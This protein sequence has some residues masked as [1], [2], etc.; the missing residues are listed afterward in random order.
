MGKETSFVFPDPGSSYPGYDAAAPTEQNEY[1]AWSLRKNLYDMAQQSFEWQQEDWDA[2]KSAINSKIATLITD[3]KAWI[4]ACYAAV[5]AGNPIPDVPN[6]W[7][8]P[9]STNMSPLTFML[10]YNAT[11]MAASI[12]N[13]MHEFFTG[14][15][16][17]K[18]YAGRGEHDDDIV[19]LLEADVAAVQTWFDAA[20]AAK[21]AGNPIPDKPTL[22]DPSDYEG[23][24]SGNQIT[25]NTQNNIR[26]KINL[27][28]MEG[29]L[30]GAVGLDE[31]D[32]TSLVEVLEDGLLNDSGD[33]LIEFL[34]AIG[35]HINLSPSGAYV[36]YGDE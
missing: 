36:E 13:L 20:I 2:S 25:L 30:K 5:S 29:A 9:V 27:S 35:L 12:L 18:G 6:F 31:S 4:D 3:I 14:K 11:F 8:N 33:P 23:I 16:G 7:V 10:F 34:A 17:S 28:L 15:W 32:L 1:L 26:L 19:D 22:S 21:L 24:M